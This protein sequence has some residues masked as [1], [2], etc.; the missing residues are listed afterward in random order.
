MH[1]SRAY[2]RQFIRDLPNKILRR[3][4]RRK[5]RG[6]ERMRPLFLGK[7]GLEIGGPS[8]IFR[9]G[10]LIPVYSCCE[11]LD[12]CNFSQKT[13]WTSQVVTTA[14]CPMSGKEFVAE[15][16]DLRGV[17]NSTYDLVL[18]SHVL[19]HIANPLRALH[20]WVRVLK[21]GGGLVVVLPDKRNTFDHKRPYTTFGHLLEDFQRGV[22]EEDLTH[23]GEILT[24]HDIALDPPAGDQE[25]FRARCLQNFAVRAMHHHVFDSELAA[26]ACEEAGLEIVNVAIEKPFHII[27]S[28]RKPFVGEVKSERGQ[29]QA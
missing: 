7:Y 28:G 27:V 15:A 17:P 13:I 21:P 6:Y 11:R 1:R 19:E 3:V 16:T 8:A 2:Y 12:L 14:P 26:A 23:L 24:L 22:G 10:R 9:D 20:E 5:C 4:T 29:W 25:S 18:A